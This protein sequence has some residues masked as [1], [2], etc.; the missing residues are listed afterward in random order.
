M[1]NWNGILKI[2]EIQHVRNNNIIWQEFNVLN[3]LHSD[4]EAFLLRCCFDNTG[5]LPPQQYYFGLD[6]RGLIETADTI[7]DLVEEPSISNGY[8]RQP[9]SSN[10]EFTIEI[11]NGVYR[12][13]SKIVSFSATAGGW[14]PVKNIFMTNLNAGGLL[15]SS[16]ALSSQISLLEGDSINLRMALSLQNF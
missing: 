8:S 16:A 3:Q 14:G 1:K 15:I 11:V 9:V 2:L 12:A 10:G 6:N 13:T 4:G 5:D 7:E